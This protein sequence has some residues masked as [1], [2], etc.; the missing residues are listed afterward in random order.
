MGAS[1]CRQLTAQG[2]TNIL[3]ATHSELDLCNQ[4]QVYDFIAQ[5]K[6]HTL[7]V[8]AARVGGIHANGTYRAEFIAENL[9]IQNNLIWGSHL[10]NIPRLVFLGSSCIYP[11][12]AP[13]PMSESALLTGELE[14]TNRPYAL[15]KIAGLELVASLRMQHG[16]NY[17]S[18]MPTNLYGPGDNFHPQNSHVLPGLLRRFW[19]AK[20]LG[21]PKVEI[22]GS[23]DA[24]REF[25]YVDD[26]AEGI[27]H[28]MENFDEK[29]IIERGLNKSGF[30]HVNLG[31]GMEVSI[32]DLSI[33]LKSIVKYE[34]EVAFDR[35]KPD[36]TPRKLL[37]SSLANA[38][39]WR[40][41]T[42]LESGIRQTFE[43]LQG[44]FANRP[45]SLRL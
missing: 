11:R 20:R 40:A 10:A 25:L 8:A 29:A 5:K 45:A 12:L 39:G 30:F 36:G 3:T 43:W 17:F 28:L 13:Q 38:M 16:R 1:L 32:R 2:Y 33:L 22:W 4:Q 34:G 42:L 15:A 27:I 23:G 26:C 6:P 9:Q 19:D 7:I 18:A 21:L 41:H 35:S 24:L 31:S 44:E 37:N 14:Y